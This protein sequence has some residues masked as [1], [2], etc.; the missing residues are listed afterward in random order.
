MQRRVYTAGE[1]KDT[2]DPFLPEKPED[3]E[4]IKALQR[5]VHEA[6]IDLVKSRRGAK[7]EKADIN[8]FTGEFWSGKKALEFGLIDGLSDLRSKMREVYGDDVRLKLVMPSTSWFRRR[9]SVFAEG[10][11]FELGLSAWRPCRRS[12]LGDR[13]AR[14]LVAFRILVDA[15]DS[16]S[17]FAAGAGLFLAG[18]WYR[19]MQRRIAA[20][21]RAAEEALER[22]ER[23]SVVPLGAGSRDRH[24]PA[25]A[26][27]ARC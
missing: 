19:D 9:R 11:G 6:F 2:L 18:R 13:S 15:A 14:A 12:H 25:E 7:I 4:R 21:L 24:L 17:S 10:G 20:E 5:D 1:S 3:V 26:D 8:L 16:S 27:G 23:E 22:R